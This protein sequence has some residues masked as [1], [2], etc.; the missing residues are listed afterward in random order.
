MPDP[1]PTPSPPGTPPIPTLVEEEMKDSYLNYAMS[2][3]VSRALPDV[4]DGLKPSQRRILFVMHELGLVP[5]GKSRKCATI[6]G[7]TMGKYHPHGDQAI[8]PTLV[9]LAQ[10]F[11]TRYLLVQGQGNFGTVDG[12]PPAAM[13]YTEAKMTP[14]TVSMIEDLEKE[15]VD[16]Q[17]NFDELLEE[18]TVLPSKFPNLLCNGAMGIAVGMA[19]SIPPHNLAEVCDALFALIA[20]PELSVAD[21]RRHVPGPDFPTGGIIMGG[22]GLREAYETGR[23]LVTVRSRV[24]VEEQKGGRKTIAVT[25]IPY[26]VNKSALIERIA[27]LVKEDQIQGIGDVRDLSSRDG[28]HIE[29]EIRKG[30]DVDVILNQLYV[31][32]S[33]QETYSI[34]MIALVGGRPRTL[35]LKDLLRAYLDHRKEVIRRRT[36]FLLDQAEREAHILEG[37]ARAI[38]LLDEIIALIRACE[39]PAAAKRRLVAE[40]GFTELQADAILKLTLAR[41]TGLEREKIL[42]DLDELRKKIA[43]YRAILADEALVLDIIREDL[44]EL[45]KASDPRR[46]EISAEEAATFEKADLIAEE[47]M[48]VVLSHTGYVK[49]VPLTSYRKQKRGGKGI[50]G[51]ETKE[52]DYIQELFIA[53]T[54]DHVLFFTDTGRVY[55]RVVFDLPQLDRTSRGKAI[56]NLLD[57]KPGERISACVSAKSFEKGFLVMATE[58]GLVKKTELSAYA[59]V[60]PSGIIAI[61][62]EEGD[63]LIGVSVT[64]GENEVILGTAEGMSIR[65]PENDLRPMGRDTYGVA[66]IKLDEGDRVV[67]MIL[68]VPDATILTACENGFGKRSPLDDYRLQ[69]RAGRG[70]INIKATERNGKVVGMKEVRDEDDLLMITQGGIVVRIPVREIRT[71]G[72]NTQGVRLIRLDEGDKL[73]AVARV[74]HEEEAGGEP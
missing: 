19:T 45:K 65:F 71:M 8:Y 70:V 46:T 18:P 35:S 56:V 3:I 30:E 11:A 52:T 15:T 47:D 26:N 31:S 32:T 36:R 20:N 10:D 68:P 59:N 13:R 5:R 40:H 14:F 72:R 48:V 25:E 27:D 55:G 2:V 64:T 24:A 41:L 62:L 73:V 23:G 57:L 61:A 17:S 54:H 67:D 21:L 50:I 33:L 38:D 69:S 7:E 63:R 58:R 53:S 6:V 12:D 44:H 66:G 39:S 1:E 34:N 51:A 9:R 43:D 4:R 42:R 60:R 28:M 22:S 37:L 49:R 74:E 16:F 29:I